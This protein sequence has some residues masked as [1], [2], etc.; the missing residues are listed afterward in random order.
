[1][2]QQNDLEIRIAA[3]TDESSIRRAKTAME[4]LADT[5]K[6]SVS[7]INKNAKGIG[8]LA[9][10]YR[11]A[12]KGA[13]DYNDELR[14]GIALARQPSLADLKKNAGL[15]GSSDTARS[16]FGG[17]GGAKGAVR[18]ALGGSPIAEAADALGDLS[19]VAGVAFQA[20]GGGTQ[21]L[22]AMGV[23]GGIVAA[24]VAAAAFAM[25]EYNKRAVEQ[26]RLLGATVEAQRQLNT[27]IANGLTSE[28]TQ[29]KLDVIN[30]EYQR[31]A[32]LL[33]DL[34]SSYRKLEEATGGSLFAIQQLD[35][36]E[37]ELSNQIT[38][39]KDLVSGLAADQRSYS[40]A[41]ED[42]SLA[43]N[44]AIAAER[45]LASERT[46]GVLS[47]A[48]AAGE[49]ET[50]RQS[51]SNK[52]REA[53][54]ASI[55]SENQRAA[56]L[57]ATLDSLKAS[58][59]T[60]E[61]VKAQI[62]LLTG[63][64]ALSAD[65]VG[66]YTSALS[67]AQTEAQLSSQKTATKAKEASAEIDQLGLSLGGLS[68]QASITRAPAA[69][70]ISIGRRLGGAS[71]AK[72]TDK[73]AESQIEYAN[74]LIEVNN[75]LGKSIDDIRLNLSRS[76]EDLSINTKRSIQDALGEGAFLSIRDIQ[77]DSRR[78]MQDLERQSNRDRIDAQREGALEILRIEQDLSMQRARIAGGGRV[79]QGGFVTIA[80]R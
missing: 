14:K 57:Q 15:G 29:E 7:V 38:A 28:Q 9:T 58:G 21:A 33:A 51:T 23:A 73:L 50:A 1:M 56:S 53:I 60:S 39:Q 26:A 22:L 69:S 13:A 70:I 78:E 41:L 52:S 3:K 2:S 6:D 77:R 12:A 8:L 66:I 18:G 20:L 44:D 49:L 43:I 55:D 67:G 31:Q 35:A 47:E 46:K 4:S 76:L 65:K 11:D 59:D 48:Q 74:S 40:T 45:A 62:E 42:G 75:T 25:G 32:V 64:L 19:E 71:A 34:E 63:Q 36:A 61:E 17:A 54:Q 72:E 68:K 30:Q 37:E 16:G 27:E 80:P 10:A 24:A 79:A 5:S